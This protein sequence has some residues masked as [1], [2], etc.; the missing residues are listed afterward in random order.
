M[1]F[2]ENGESLKHVMYQTCHVLKYNKV[3]L[4][5]L[6]RHYAFS[7]QKNAFSDVLWWSS[8]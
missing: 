5:Y 3:I 4:T 2:S 7:S 1:H 6:N 8:S